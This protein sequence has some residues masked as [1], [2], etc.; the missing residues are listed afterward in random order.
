MTTEL[1]FGDLA[2]IFK[3][4]VELNRS[5]LSVCDRWHLFFLKTILFESQILTD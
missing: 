1:V 4:L 3:I 2:L 5:N